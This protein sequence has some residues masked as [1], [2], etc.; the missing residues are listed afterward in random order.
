MPPMSEFGAKNTGPS[1]G[2]ERSQRSGSPQPMRN[3]AC[4]R[5]DVESGLQSSSNFSNVVGMNGR[6][7][8]ENLYAASI[9]HNMA[10][11]SFRSAAG[12]S[13]MTEETA[14]QAAEKKALEEE[15][16]A[17]QRQYDKEAKLE[18]FRAKTA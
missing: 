12:V 15:L 4:M 7:T 11:P 14:M 3:E 1:L 10:A 5:C 8:G 18:Q 16:K 17:K 13:V 9:S 2:K 6:P